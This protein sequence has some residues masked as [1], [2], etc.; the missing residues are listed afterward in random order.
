VEIL[1]QVSN[2]ELTALYDVADLFLSASEHEGFCVPLVEAFYKRVPVVARAA[3]AV[4]ATMD[5]GGVL[6]SSTDPREVA[7]LVHQVLSHPTLEAD[8]LVKQDEALDR[9]LAQDFAGR[10]VGFVRQATQAPRQSHAAVSDDFWTQ[11]RL[12]EELETIRQL[13]PA[14]FRALPE[15]P[16]DRG[17]VSDLSHRR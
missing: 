11:F 7:A 6:Y 14:A 2:E 15:S 10:V 12:A 4:P 13:R 16:I 3:T 1:G 8:I 9:L 5:G 17:H